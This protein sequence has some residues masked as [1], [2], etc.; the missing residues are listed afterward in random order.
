M[1]TLNAKAQPVRN[2]MNSVKDST[3]ST[4]QHGKETVDYLSKFLFIDLF[5]SRF[6][7]QQLQQ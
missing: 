1:N 7:M 3:T 6:Q 2:V 5:I 4:I